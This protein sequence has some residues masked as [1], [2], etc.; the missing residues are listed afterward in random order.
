MLDFS[1]VFALCSA[2]AFGGMIATKQSDLALSTILIFGML[3]CI[4]SVFVSLLLAVTGYNAQFEQFNPQLFDA[5]S[6][7]FKP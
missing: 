3:T 6:R 5:L 4:C 7:F 1:I 2:V